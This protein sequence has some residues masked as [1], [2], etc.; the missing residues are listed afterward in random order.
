MQTE[1][2]TFITPES[3]DDQLT[4]LVGSSRLVSMEVGC[5]MIGCTPAGMRRFIR[6]HRVPEG[7]VVYVGRNKKLNLDVLQQIVRG[8]AR[9]L[10]AHEAHAR[11]HFYSH[12]VR[13]AYEKRCAKERV[14]AGHSP[15]HAQVTYTK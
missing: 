11:G 3:I 6:E 14:I 13:A 10:S 8:E 5:T 2:A 1:T 4:C 15:R 12:D 7:L 9:I